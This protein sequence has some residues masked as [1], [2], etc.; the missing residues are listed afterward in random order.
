MNLF[1]NVW[2]PLMMKAIVM[3]MMVMMIM[4]YNVQYDDN[5]SDGDFKDDESPVFQ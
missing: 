3:H 4:I 5:V 2:C 1:S